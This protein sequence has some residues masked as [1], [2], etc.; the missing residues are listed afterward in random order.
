MRRFYGV[1]NGI[2]AKALKTRR[3]EGF[4]IE[5]ERALSPFFAPANGRTDANPF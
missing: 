4:L 1:C 5:G 2:A 3:F